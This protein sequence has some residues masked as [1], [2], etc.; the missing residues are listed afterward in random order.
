MRTL[1][2]LSILFYFSCKSHYSNHL[3][4]PQRSGIVIEEIIKEIPLKQRDAMEWLITYMPEFDLKNLSHEFLIENSEYAFK[5]KSNFHWAED[6]P[7]ELF[8]NYVLPYSSLNER[9]ESWRK[10]FFYKFSP[11]VKNANS[12]YEAA[13]ILNNEIFKIL[14]VKYSTK[15]PK[16]DQ[17]PYESIEAGLASCTGLSF[18]L[19]DACRSVGIPARFVGTPM[20]YNDSGNHSWVEIWDGK[21]HFTGAAEPVDNKLNQVW[22]SDLATKAKKGDMK[23]GIFAATWSRTEVYFPMDWLPGVKTFN[24]IDVT[25]QYKNNIQTDS[26]LVAVSIRALNKK[27]QRESVSVIITGE[28]N[29]YFKGQ[30]KNETHDMNDHLRVLL[31]K[32]KIFTIQ[33]DYDTQILEIESDCLVS[34]S[35]K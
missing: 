9:R 32:G 21:W 29:F 15:R 10:D 4:N 5:A 22:F 8:L 28:D 24:A 26:D 25:D 6:L 16:A 34:L 3:S 7:D 20:W 14:G 27:G 12:A 17:S 13:V 31:P 18:L 23:Y 30:S 2:F 33:S 19:I 35:S 11:V 1:F